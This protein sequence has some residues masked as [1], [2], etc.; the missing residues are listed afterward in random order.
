MA[1]LALIGP[2]IDVFVAIT[3]I[4]RPDFSL[5]GIVEWLSPWLLLL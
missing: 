5:W 2:Q 4:F 1:D 3:P